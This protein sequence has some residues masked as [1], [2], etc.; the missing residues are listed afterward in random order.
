MST[1]NVSLDQS[2]SYLAG[3]CLFTFPA[4]TQR[5]LL[6]GGLGGIVGCCVM[7]HFSLYTMLPPFMGAIGLFIYFAPRALHY[8]GPARFAHVSKGIVAHYFSFATATAFPSNICLFWPM[9]LHLTY[10][11]HS[12]PCI[13]PLI[14]WLVYLFKRLCI[15]AALSSWLTSFA[16]GGVVG[17]TPGSILWL[18]GPAATAA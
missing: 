9:L 7:L 18:S 10:N 6:Q 14:S 16:L 11:S 4:L 2:P 17:D 12:G 15:M 3:S 8:A 1:C 5:L 13:V